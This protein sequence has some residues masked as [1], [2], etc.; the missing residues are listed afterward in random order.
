MSRSYLPGEQSAPAGW[1]N[2]N[3]K[4]EKETKPISVPELL[5]MSCL[6]KLT[7]KYTST[8]NV[9]RYVLGRD[10]VWLATWTH[11][12]SH[13]TCVRKA[14]S[15]LPVV[16]L[17]C[18]LVSPG[19]TWRE[20]PW[21]WLDKRPSTSEWK[22]PSGTSRKG[23]LQRWSH[24][25]RKYRHSLKCSDHVDHDTSTSQSLK[26]RC[27]KSN[28]QHAFVISQD[29]SMTNQVFMQAWGKIRR[30]TCW[31]NPQHQNRV[32]PRKCNSNNMVPYIRHT[33]RPV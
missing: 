27:S 4:T 6:S 17:T 5:D 12:K 9:K 29:I 22:P 25:S 14:E 15:K 19:G 30:C 26:T 31:H 11:T 24:N 16:R 32:I 2:N 3:A 7:Q 28:H 33:V 20:E 21:L 18:G 10:D 1:S 23:Y 13:G 8:M